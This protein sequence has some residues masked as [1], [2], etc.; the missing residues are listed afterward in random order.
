MP[1]SAITG[2]RG[3]VSGVGF[4]GDVSGVAFRGDVVG[5]SLREEAGLR[6]G[7]VGEALREEVSLSEEAGLRDGE[8][9]RD[10]EGEEAE[11]VGVRAVAGL[12]ADCGES[13]VGE[14]ARVRGG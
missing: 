8:A 6:A 12:G 11:E 1:G 7:A 5:L 9:A 2:L 14:G 13:R 4:R 10:L 3:V